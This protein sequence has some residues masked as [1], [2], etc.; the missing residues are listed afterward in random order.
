MAIIE[1]RGLARTFKSRKRVVEAVRGVDLTVEPGEI[2][3]FL[4]PNG[5]GKTTTLRML[6]TLLSPTAGTATVAGADLLKDPLGVRRRIGYVPQAI[7]ATG[8]GSDP[9]CLVREELLDQAAL[10]HLPAA[11]A[12]ERAELLATQLELAGLEDR[13]VK[14]LSG[15]QRRRL[16]IALGLVHAPGL[17]FLDEPTTGLDPQS[18]SH[19]WDHVRGIR[20]GLGTTIFLTTHYLEEA[21]ALCDRVLIIDNGV[22]VAEGTPDEL[23]R[24]ISGDVVTLH[25]NGDTANAEGLLSPEPRVREITSADGVLRLTVSRGEEALPALLHTLDAAGITLQSISLSRP[26][27]DDVFLTLTGRSLR[28]DSPSARNGAQPTAAGT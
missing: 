3:G 11:K 27:L 17:V 25:V 5:A 6:T 26:T 1:A 7:G 10:Y 16:D 28:D 24:R 22:I 8:G 18:R 12:R 2:V 23:K 15:G 21:D 20:S 14:T 13:R 19:L 9:N 4:G